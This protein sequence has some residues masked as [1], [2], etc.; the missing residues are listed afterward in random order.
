MRDMIMLLLATTMGE[1]ILVET[2]RSAAYFVTRSANNFQ[3]KHHVTRELLREARNCY[4]FI[5]GTGLDELIATYSLDYDPEIIRQ[6]FNFYVRQ[7]S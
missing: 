4:F 2:L 6:G 7:S 5:Q 1:S 3:P